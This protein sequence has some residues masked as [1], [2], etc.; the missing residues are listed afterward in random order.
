MASGVD[1]V[2]PVANITRCNALRHPGFTDVA[3]G[4][5]FATAPPPTIFLIQLA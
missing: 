3:F 1:E 4:E 2:H 5:T